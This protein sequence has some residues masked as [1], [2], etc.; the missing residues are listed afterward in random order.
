MKFTWHWR[1]RQ[2]YVQNCILRSASHQGI[3]VQEIH[4]AVIMQGRLPIHEI[5]D[6]SLV[7]PSYV[8][9]W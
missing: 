3:D 4:R 7:F 2:Q 5:S 1:K 8:G 9:Q 6:L